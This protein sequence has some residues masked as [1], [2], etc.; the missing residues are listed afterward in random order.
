[1]WLI[2]KSIFITFTF[3]K[4]TLKEIKIIIYIQMSRHRNYVFTSFMNDEPEYDPDV[5]R[6]ICWQREQCP[7]T[8][9]LHYQGYVE[10]KEGTSLKNAK[11]RLGDCSAHLEVRKGTQKQAIK[12][13]KKSKTAIADTYSEYGVPARQGNRSDLDDMVD[14]I[15]NGATSLEILLEHRGNALRHLGMITRGLE[16]FHGMS[17][18]DNKIINKRALYEEIGLDRFE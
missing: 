4:K 7:S 14:M 1:M 8:G 12:Y 5:M 18:V 2:F 6:F 11:N 10:F 15:E 13:C 16:A 3:M 17:A 9:K